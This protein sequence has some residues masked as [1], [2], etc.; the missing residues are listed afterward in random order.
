M[1]FVE[2]HVRIGSVTKNLSPFPPLDS[3]ASKDETYCSS[4]TWI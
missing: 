3:Q 2:T 4:F 1:P